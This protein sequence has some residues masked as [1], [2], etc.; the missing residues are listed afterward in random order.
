MSYVVENYR[1]IFKIILQNSYN[2]LVHYARVNKHM[3][4]LENIRNLTWEDFLEESKG[5]KLFTLEDG[6]KHFSGMDYSK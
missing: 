4:E 3:A 6:L 2:R 1:E 5:T